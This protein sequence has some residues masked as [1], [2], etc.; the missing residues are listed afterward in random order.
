MQSL[1]HGN[2]IMFPVQNQ[3]LNMY[4]G[5]IKLGSLNVMTESSNPMRIV[6]RDS[7]RIPYTV[8]LLKKENFDILAL[9]EMSIEFLSW[10]QE[11]E[12][13]R[14]NYFFSDICHESGRTTKNDTLGTKDQGNLILTKYP[15]KEL[16]SNAISN[17]KRQLHLWA[18]N[19]PIQKLIVVVSL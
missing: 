18:S 3:M 14:T 10:L 13:F 6:F 12:F 7:E 4:N 19:T 17:A 16:F 9:N 15:P 5:K 1:K 2:E 8:Q 11:D